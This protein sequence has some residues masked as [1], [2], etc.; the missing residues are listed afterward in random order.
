[1]KTKALTTLATAGLMAAGLTALA[2]TP[3]TLK[4]KV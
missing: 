2:A 4:A 1:M 3:P